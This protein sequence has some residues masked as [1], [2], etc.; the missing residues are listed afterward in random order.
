MKMINLSDF[1]ASLSVL[2]FQS[3]LAEKILLYSCINNWCF[4]KSSHWSFVLKE[5]RTHH[6]REYVGKLIL[7]KYY[8]TREEHSQWIWWRCEL[9]PY[10]QRTH[11]NYLTVGLSWGH[12]AHSRLTR[13]AC[14]CELSVSLQTVT[15]SSLLPLLCDLI[16]WSH[17]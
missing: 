14:C 17:K 15:V 11:L 7:Y 12:S 8:F 16:G 9:K 10:S 6:I 5:D 3:K 4:L 13:R 1:N 2:Q